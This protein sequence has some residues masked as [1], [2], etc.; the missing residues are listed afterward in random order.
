MTC[1]FL[2]CNFWLYIQQIYLK[3]LIRICY[4]YF[5]GNKGRVGPPGLTG[6]VG[7]AGPVGQD[8]IEGITGDDGFKGD[9]GDNGKMGEK[10]KKG[11]QVHS[12]RLRKLISGFDLWKINEALN[13]I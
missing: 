11:A 1:R 12:L 10:G 2:F 5:Q 13:R 7:L 6:R 4:I 8:G 9:K 3:W